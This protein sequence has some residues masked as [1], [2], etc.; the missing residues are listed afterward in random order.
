MRGCGSG[1]SRADLV[2]PGASEVEKVSL[3]GSL[4]DSGSG[5]LAGGKALISCCS[6]GLL[7]DLLSKMLLDWKNVTIAHLLRNPLW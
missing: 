2:S 5:L 7:L 6:V 1:Q 3:I 4:R